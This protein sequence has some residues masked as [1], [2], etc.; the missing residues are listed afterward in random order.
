[1]SENETTSV[2]LPTTDD[3]RRWLERLDRLKAGEA[4]MKARHTA[5]EKVLKMKLTRLDK[6]IAAASAFVE[7]EAEVKS[8]QSPKPHAEELATVHVP[9]TSTPSAKTG[10]QRAKNKTWTATILKIVKKAGRGMTYG[11]L[12]EEIA[13]THLGETLKRTEKAFYGGIGKLAKNDKI[14]KHKGRVF[15][16]SVYRQFME[17]VTAGRAVDFPTPSSGGESPNEIAVERLLS[18]RPDGATASE[19]VVSLLVNPPPDLAVTKNRN[20]IYNLL[21][22][23]RKR[24]K[25]IRRGNRYYLSAPKDEALG[26]SEPSATNNHGGGNGGLPSSGGGGTSTSLAALPGAIPAHPGE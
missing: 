19:I 4:E 14:I 3:V 22:R 23:Q 16:Q 10:R 26:S 13:Q 24:G 7:A 12:K 9:S 25:L 21:T 5:E 8:E 2:N 6:L 15:T 18:S 11:E 20:S 17:D 1:M